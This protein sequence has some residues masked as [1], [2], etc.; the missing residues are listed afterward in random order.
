[1]IVVNPEDANHTFDII[2]RYYPSQIVLTL[3]NEVTKEVDILDSTVIVLPYP[4]FNVNDGIMTVNFPFTFTEQAKYQIKITDENGVVFRG[5]L[6]STS[7]IPQ[8]YKQTNNLY[9]YE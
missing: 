1:M 3:Y 4:F 7:Q 9:V 5:K 8:D 6:I 2:P